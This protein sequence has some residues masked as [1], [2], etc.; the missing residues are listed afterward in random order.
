MLTGV[1]LALLAGAAVML[2]PT[3]N[4]MTGDGPPQPPGPSPAAWLARWRER[5]SAAR[6]LQEELHVIDALAAALEAGLP[7]PRAVELAVRGGGE[8]WGGAGDGGVLARAAREG[9]ELAPAWERLARQGRSPT[10]ASVSRAWRVASLTGAPLAHALRVSAHAAR[11]RRRL[12]RAVEVAVAG[13]RA[14]VGVLTL[15]PLAGVGLAAALGVGPT[16]LYADPVAQASAG[17]GALLLLAGQV[18]VRR[19]VGSVVGRVG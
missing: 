14:T 5:P 9:Q 4:P 11:E 16:S 3:E 7:V 19:M 13:P 15:L 8:G 18:W 12:V 2:W 1:L 6:S 10:V 17:A